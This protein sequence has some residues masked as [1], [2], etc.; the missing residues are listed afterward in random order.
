M[1]GDSDNRNL[2]LAAVLAMLVVFAW[3]AFVVPPP[4][5]PTEQAPAEG[6]PATVPA[7]P[8]ETAE[9]TASSGTPAGV[10]V[11]REEALKRDNR[12]LI[13]TPAVTGSI[14]LTGGRLDD[15][16]L[17]L[18]RES[19]EP[20]ADTV[21]LLNPVGAADPYFIDYGWRRTVN[22]DPG[23]LP[24]PETPW[25]VESGEKLTPSTPVVLRWDN[26]RGLTFRRTFAID[27]RYMLT[28]TQSVENATAETVSLAPYGAIA[29]QG[30][31]PGVNFY[32]LHE[33]AIGMFDGT[34]SEVDYDEMRDLDVSKEE[35]GPAQVTHVEQNGWLGFTDKYW[36]STLIPA[37]GESFDAVYRVLDLG[38]IEEFR[39]EMRLPVVSVPAGGKVES[40]TNLFSGA[41]EVATIRRY[42]KELGIDRFDD[43]VDWGW[44]YFL[45]K[46]IFRLLTWVHALVGN[47]GVA[48][49]VLTFIVKAA[50][51]PL[52]YKSFVAMSQMKKLQ[53]EMERIKEQCGDD[54]QKLQQEIMALYKK[55][56]VN[57]AS[58]CLP[59]LLQ[60]P[61]FF[62]LYKV[63]FVT[64]EMR[65]APFVGWIKDLSAPDP[66]SW[67]NLF[68][69]LPFEPA[70][71]LPGILMPV[72]I[73]VYPILLGVTMWLQQKL[74]PAPADPTQR[75]IFAWMPWLFMFLLGQFAS[76]L[77]IYWC[78]NNILSFSQQ[79]II[80]RSQGI[81]VDLLGNIKSGLKPKRGAKA[82]TG[83]RASGTTD[84][85]KD[86][87]ESAALAGGTAA[88]EET[89]APADQPTAKAGA[90]PAATPA[91][92]P[93]HR[94]SRRRSGGRT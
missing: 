37:P 5:P 20:N 53:P 18:Y 29:R 83:N 90:R 23:P 24:G 10:P 11:S 12:V 57:P 84:G 54:R 47:M 3:Q 59:I 55:E 44:F 86:R 4:P 2:I 82:V 42:Q 74:N 60:I 81:E 41:K 68:G 75:L 51:F 58:G 61:I 94:A 28:V 78:A 69:L 16:H 64:I 39:T 14:R 31:P 79:Y 1:G 33:G 92:R 66:S 49:I 17:S 46:P 27:D 19:L 73:G 26:G 36:M 93:G 50:L 32:I 9:G 45:T 70:A 62:A 43:S 35:R 80:M 34:L 87:P 25:Q 38:T 67:I 65:H 76:G 56:K 15:L 88:K 21:T 7:A 6:Q 71:V 8:G 52:A 48:I 77:V 13:E 85:G 40:V 72:S 91:S 30:E 89:P 22:Q 63:L